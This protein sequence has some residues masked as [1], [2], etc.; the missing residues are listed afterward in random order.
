MIKIYLIIAFS[1]VI[2][3]S[4]AQFK[5]SGKIKDKKN[6]DPLPYVSV[7]E[8][9]TTIGTTTNEYGEYNLTVSDKS[10]TLVFSFVGYDKAEEL[11][12]G[13]SIVD[14]SLSTSS[15]LLNEVVVTALG[16]K[17]ATKNLGYG[18]QRVE[19]KRISEVKSAN[20]VDNLA[21]NIAGVSVSQGATGVGS[22]SKITIRGEASFTNNNPLFV[23]D[24]VPIN[25]SSLFN[26]TTEAAAGFQEVDFGNGGMEINQDD[27]EDVTVLKGPGAAALYGTRAANGVILVTTKDGSKSKGLGVSINST[28]FIESAF[29]LPQFQNKYG[30]GNSGQFQYVDGLGGGTNDGITYSWGPELDQGTLIQQFD[31]PVTLPDGSVVRGGDVA[32]HGGAPITPTAFNS[33]PDNLKDFYKTG[34]TTINNFSVSNGFDKGSIYASYTDL[35]SESIIP[36]VNLDRKTL[37]TRLSFQPIDKL[38][39]STSINYI[40]SQSDNRPSGGYGSENIGYSMVAW[41]PRSLNTESLVDY[42]QPGLEGLQQYSFNTT[43]FDNPYFILLENRNAFNRDRLMGHISASYDFTEDLKLIVTSGMDYSNE[44]REYRRAYSTNRFKTGAYA[45]QGVFFREI[46][47]NFLLSHKKILGDFTTDFSVGGNRMDQDAQTEQSQT[48][49]LAQP[50]TFNFSNAASPIEIFQQKAQKRINSLYGIARLGY[51]DFIYLDVTGRN[52][53]SSALATTTSTENTSFFYPSVSASYILSSTVQLPNWVSFTKVR[54]SL[55]QVG[56]DTDPYST[57]SSFVSGT[58]VNSQPTFSG[59]N[60]LPNTNLSP[61]KTTAVEVG[62]LI[63]FFK[64]RLSFDVTYYNELTKNQILS[65]P[66]SIAS[67][68]TQQVVNGGAVRSQGVEVITNITPIK[69]EHFQWTTQ[70]NFSTNRATVEELPE[71]VDRITLG[72]SRVYDNVNQTVWFQVEEGGR[73]GDIYGTGYKRN[74]N[75]D[76]IIDANGRHI[77]NNDLIKLGNANP[78]FA[79]GINNSFSYRNWELGFL[80]DWRQGG[81]LVSRTLALAGVGGQLEETLDRPDAGIVAEGVVNKGTEENPIWE[82]NTTAVTAESYY[83]E[84]YDRN[85]EENNTY[86]ASYLKLRQFS[87]GYSFK[88]N[89]EKGLLKKGRD[90][91]VAFIGR[92]LFAW[93]KIPHFDPEQIAVQGNR[94]LSGVEDIS[95]ATARSFGF[96]IGYNF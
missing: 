51:K 20:F 69:K 34:V 85:H 28:T 65:L 55:A 52:D 43:F 40:N 41:G 27:I 92:N 18:I 64:N 36:G 17:R 94:I 63:G 31:S 29:Q 49:S 45:E 22:T 33:N 48:L 11:I 8:K 24:G 66:I 50:G 79:I 23:V 91:R 60:L 86:D 6:G 25:N 89:K 30:Q 61:E 2:T 46:N 53:W 10:A 87:I 42:W 90:L 58:P 14:Y 74:E 82:Q 3:F 73:I 70:L 4:F 72:Y 88:A 7:G 57:S 75:G 81:E 35:R 1:F 59:N 26:N 84:F 78:D 39:F 5:V 16:Q 56:N 76:F 47:T 15:D 9:G 38:S 83:R 21:G 95:Y 37:A 62:G 12:N 96:K 44:L 32:V 80:F 19:G 13:R 54:A 71:G 68:A 77:V 93:S 67:G